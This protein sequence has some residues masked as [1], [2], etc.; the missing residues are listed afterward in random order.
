MHAAERFALLA[1][2]A[3]PARP[4]NE[5]L[6]LDLLTTLANTACLA[7][8]GE[9]RQSL[10]VTEWLW[11]GMELSLTEEGDGD[12]LALHFPF[13]LE[14]RRCMRLSGRD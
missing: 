5:E 1:R 6:D 2:A 3:K 11:S 12:G 9:L 8:T 14:G 13:P 4:F 7:H 10:L